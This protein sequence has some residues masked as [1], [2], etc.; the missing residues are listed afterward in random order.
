M[1]SL[2]EI[3][4]ARSHGEQK[5]MEATVRVRMNKVVIRKTMVMG[6]M[7]ALAEVEILTLPEVVLKVARKDLGMMGQ[8]W[9]GMTTTGRE[10]AMAH[11]HQTLVG[12]VGLAEGGGDPHGEGPLGAGEL[13]VVIVEAA[14]VGGVGVDSIFQECIYSFL[15]ADIRSTFL[16][17]CFLVNHHHSISPVIVNIHNVAHFIIGVTVL[18]YSL[19][20]ASVT[21]MFAIL[22][23]L[24]IIR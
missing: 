3:P 17:V 23:E 22:S 12:M 9:R 10:M 15:S 19:S 4:Q 24:F 16:F 11:H 7:V 20:S 2:A 13:S 8:A 1:T 5:A 14:G 18:S 6:V 21:S